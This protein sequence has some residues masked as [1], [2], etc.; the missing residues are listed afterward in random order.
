MEF[1]HV[2]HEQTHKI[3]RD[4]LN[5]LFEDIHEDP[6][7]GHF[8]VGYGSTVMEASIEPYGPEERSSWLR[9]TASRA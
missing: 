7:N 3:V 1:E 2:H 6:E 9:P 8:N 4:Y 5:E